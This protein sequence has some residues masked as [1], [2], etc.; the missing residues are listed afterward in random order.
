MKR[1]AKRGFTLVEL[2]IVLAIVG[3]LSAI[4]VPNF[5]KYIKK[6]RTTEARMM[7]EKAYNGARSYYLEV[8]ESMSQFTGASAQF[9]N[10]EL[11][12]PGASCCSLGGTRCE[13]NMFIWDGSATWTALK[14]SMSD[15]HYYQYQF[16]GVGAGNNARFSATAYG[17]LDC[18]GIKSTFQMWGMITGASGGDP[19]LSAAAS[20]QNELE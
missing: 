14:F 11:V 19:T 6:S 12:T 15:P 4:A 8:T 5:M 9:P 20:R 2:M 3:I 16:D 13:P 18:D 1:I 7:L 17:D 10:S